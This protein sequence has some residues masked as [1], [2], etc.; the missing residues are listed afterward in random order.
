[1]GADTTAK[2]RGKPFQ[3]GVSG[4]PAGRPKGSR[5]KLSEDF[6]AALAADFDAHGAHAIE[7]M[8]VKSPAQYVNVIASLVPKDLNLKG[9]ASEAF[10]AML[11][12]IS[13][14]R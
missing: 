8:R 10:V 4:N 6:V 13:N 2:S 5:N 14:D 7:V 9:D 12:W 3:K 1:M 11:K